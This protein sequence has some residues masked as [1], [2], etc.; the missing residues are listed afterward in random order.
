MEIS[1]SS[2]YASATPVAAEMVT[3]SVSFALRLVCIVFFFGSVLLLCYFIYPKLPKEPAGDEE[4]GEPL[5]PEI[6]LVKEW[7]KGGGCGD[8][9]VITTEVC[10]ICL[11]DFRENDAVRVLVR[12]RHVYHVQC[13][14]SWCLYKLACPVC[15]APFRFF[16]H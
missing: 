10:V 6:I 12:C 1:G 5:P 7:E 8:D 13:I 3:E 4:S 2:G 11:E 15:R 14:D 9:G 16:G